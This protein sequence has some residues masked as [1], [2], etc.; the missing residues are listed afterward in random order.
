M[1]DQQHK[2]ERLAPPAVVE[3]R[4]AAKVSL[5]SRYQVLDALGEGGMGMVYRV[6]DLETG[7]VVALKV[8]RPEL[9]DDAKMLERFKDELRLARRITH[10]N[11]CRI[12]DFNRTA[13]TA[14]ITM[15]YV[16]GETLRAHLKRVG[17][18]SLERV[19]DLAN[20]IC[21]GLAEAHAQRVIHRDLKPENV[22][23]ARDG[24]VKLMDFGIA[25]LTG[26]STTTSQTLIG[27]PT[28]MAPEQAEGKPVDQR[29]DLYALGL[30]LYECLT[31]R[32]AFVGDTPVAIALKQLKE[33]PVAPRKLAPAIPHHVETAILRCLEKD[34]ARRF[35]SA[36]ALAA[37]LRADK[38]A[39]AHRPRR[40]LVWVGTLAIILIAV[41]AINH[42]K[43]VR[44][45]HLLA[46]AKPVETRSSEPPVSASVGEASLADQEATSTQSAAPVDAA[47]PQSSATGQ[48]RREQLR[49]VVAAA[50]GGDADAQ[51]KLGQ[52]LLDGPPRVRDQEKAR[53]LFQLA[54]QT[55]H[56]EAQYH[57]A[58][59]YEN[60]RG[61]T[62]NLV[63]AYAL[64]SLAANAGYGP[65]RAE[66]D[67]LAQQLG[68]RE[69]ARGKQRARELAKERTP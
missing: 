21:A 47:S 5:P 48:F 66:R 14:Y 9:A 50:R 55:G 7:E 15:E 30:L 56:P 45:Q 24:T 60:G 58:R 28:Y 54:A 36:R 57:L 40:R 31:G 42:A 35:P 22:V 63:G 13:S 68:E 43:K 33:K 59:M 44:Q 19:L 3:T 11:I 67:R 4:V 51:N 69:V 62:K 37:A 27:T 65:A 1:T 10:K 29:T 61:G 49:Q 20:Q 46:A 41:I 53:H 39:R 8:L 12:Y 2:T 34:P 26:G 6:R 64:Y 17:K 18:M 23:I 25:R 16:D 38:A 32:M 52:F